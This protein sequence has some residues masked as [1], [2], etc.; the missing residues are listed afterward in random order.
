MSDTSFNS[1]AIS[2]ILTGFSR[3]SEIDFENPSKLIVISLFNSCT[4]LYNT[5][6]CAVKLFVAATPISGPQF[7]PNTTSPLRVSD[8]VSKLTI[9]II[10]QLLFFAILTASKTSA[11]SPLWDIAI[12]TESSSIVSGANWS[13]LAIIG[14]DFIFTYFDKI[15]FAINAEL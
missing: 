3:I 10:L 4:I 12:K 13:S 14:S 5:I 11:L 15:C 1:F 8:D 9:E 2:W 7:I 6:S